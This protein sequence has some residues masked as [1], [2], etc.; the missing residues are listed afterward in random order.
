MNQDWL[1]YPYWWNDP[2]EEEDVTAAASRCLTRYERA[3]L[4][5][6]ADPGPWRFHLEAMATELKFLIEFVEDELDKT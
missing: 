6:E 3:K 2:P 5:Y 1:A 4:S